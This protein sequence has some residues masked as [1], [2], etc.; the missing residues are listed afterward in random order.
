LAKSFFIGV[1]GGASKCTVRVEDEAGN[2]LGQAVSG[3]ANIRISVPLAWQSIQ[4]AL[5]SVLKPLGVSLHD[6]DNK[7]HA[8]VG[9]AGCELALAYQAFTRFPHKFHTLV[10]TTDAHAACLGAHNG[11]DGTLIIAGT[12]VAGY[13]IENGQSVKVS[14]W[15]FPHDDIGSG[16]WLGLE[17]AR[18]AMQWQDGRTPSSG[19]AKAVMAHFD[20][21]FD[22]FV[23][24]ANQAN[25]TAFAE[26]APLVIQVSKAGDAAATQLLRNAARALDAVASALHAKQLD[27]SHT[28]PCAL[29]GGIAP[30]IQPFLGDSLRSRLTPCQLPPEAG[31]ILFIRQEMAAEKEKS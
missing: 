10:V 20:H 25:S 9:I 28:L 19:L 16:A 26:L 2:L 6:P 18:V 23:N 14:G 1:D 7:F 31:A 27:K 21:N 13:Q 17:A 15:G 5:E 8:G 22:R 12:G 29:A 4:N 30:F 24:W 11:Q 3:P